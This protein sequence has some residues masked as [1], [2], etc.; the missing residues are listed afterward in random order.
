MNNPKWVMFV[1]GARNEK[2]LG[3]GILVRGP[4]GV[5]MEY[6]LRF[7]FPTTNNEAEMIGPRTYELENLNR[8]IIPRSWH[9]SNLTKN[10]V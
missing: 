10:Y 1:D 4:D 9:A 5:V 6:E 8:E 7:T 2:G 3:I